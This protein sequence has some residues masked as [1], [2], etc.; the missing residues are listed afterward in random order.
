MS[1]GADTVEAELP[2]LTLTAIELNAAL[3]N[4]EVSEVKFRLRFAPAE[5][6]NSVVGTKYAVP[7]V[8]AVVQVP[9]A[10]PL[11]QL[12]PKLAPETTSFKAI[13][14]PPVKNARPLTLSF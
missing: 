14:L 9:G 13:D 4:P 8:Q 11:K 6:S 5:I 2:M 10:V 1:P 12:L 3:S 7:A